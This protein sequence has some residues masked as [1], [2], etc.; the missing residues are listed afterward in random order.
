[1][2]ILKILVGGGEGMLKLKMLGE[3]YN[4][5]ENRGGGGI[6]WVLFLR[7]RKVKWR[8]G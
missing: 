8:G 7:G 5:N 6:F 2:S 1:M 3:R 4:Y